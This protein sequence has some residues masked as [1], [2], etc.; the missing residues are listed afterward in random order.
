M[1]ENFKLS[2]LKV[3]MVAYER[4]SHTVTTSFLTEHTPKNVC[5]GIHVVLLSSQYIQVN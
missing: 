3:I 4:W 2:P 1:K 5:N